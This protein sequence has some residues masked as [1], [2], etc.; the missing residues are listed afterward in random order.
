[1]A[2]DVYGAFDRFERKMDDAIGGFDILLVQ[3]APGTSSYTQF[4]VHLEHLT[5]EI[6]VVLIRTFLSLSSR[7]S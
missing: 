5:Q 6:I 1:M 3:D 2:D 4:T 7:L